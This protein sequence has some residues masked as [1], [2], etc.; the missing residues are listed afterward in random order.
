[1]ERDRGRLHQ[2][3]IGST[4]WCI[5]T[6]SIIIKHISEYFASNT[7][8]N[9]FG[10]PA[11]VDILQL[12]E[13]WTFLSSHNQWCSANGGGCMNGVSTLSESPGCTSSVMCRRESNS[14]SCRCSCHPRRRSCV[15]LACVAPSRGPKW[16][17]W[18]HRSV[19]FAEDQLAVRQYFLRPVLAPHG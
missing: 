18:W 7:Y 12:W 1:M 19:S 4:Q 2:H 15:V 16:G 17:G 14:S 6:L 9:T 13:R 8:R 10:H 3:T 11:T 5:N